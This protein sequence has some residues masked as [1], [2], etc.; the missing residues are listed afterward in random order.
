MIANQGYI[1]ELRRTDI[2]R[3]DGVGRR[4]VLVERLMRSLARNVA[5]CASVATLSRD[6]RGPD[7]GL[8]ERTVVDYL[9]ALER[10]M[11]RE[12]QPPWASHI[13]SRSRLRSRPKRH[14][15]DLRWRPPRYALDLRRSE[16]TRTRRARET[17]R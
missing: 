17:C 8:A 5:T 4:P 2:R 16:E 14:F 9:E 10:L 7:N 15:V 12:D 1:E 3:V 6:A 13:R 11:V